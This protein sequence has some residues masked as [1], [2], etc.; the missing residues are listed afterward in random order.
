MK[1]LANWFSQVFNLLS[2]KNDLDSRLPNISVSLTAVD[3]KTKESVTNTK[4][5]I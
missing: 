3:P 5:G 4:S 1:D 2:T